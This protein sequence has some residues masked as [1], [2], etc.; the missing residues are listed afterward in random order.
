MGRGCTP[1]ME[2]TRFRMR[3]RMFSP[4][5]INPFS[6]YKLIR[7]TSTFREIKAREKK[8][9]TFDQVL[10]SFESPQQNR[11]IFTSLGKFNY[12]CHRNRG[13]AQ[14]TRSN[15]SSRISDVQR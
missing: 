1:N 14:R 15:G 3:L 9:G 6:G 13:R 8:K 11:F 2:F 4:R 10:M 7:L 5:W 12:T